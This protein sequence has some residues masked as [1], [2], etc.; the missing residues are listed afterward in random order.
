MFNPHAAQTLAVFSH[1]NHELSVLMTLAR[2]EPLIVFLT[3]GGGPARVE[4]SRAGLKTVGLEKKARFMQNTEESFYRAI[5]AKDSSFFK[6]VAA[7]LSNYLTLHEPVQIITDAV[8]FYNPVH[9]ISLPLVRKAVGSSEVPIY[10]VPL[11]Y[12]QRG[13]PDCYVLQD[14]PPVWETEHV[15]VCL[16]DEESE[17][18]SVAYM[19]DY[20]IIRNTMGLLVQ[21]NPQVLRREILVRARKP[22]SP[23][24]EHYGRRYDRRGKEGVLAGTY[25]QAILS[26][27][28]Y[29]ETVAGLMRESV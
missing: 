12:E 6:G 24:F 8:E 20:G 28:H 2:V 26:D 1:P 7:H 13:M 21:A 23:A 14:A 3:D 17:A 15:E 27:V 19:N 22:D 25:E 18:K 11:I 5:L 9:D 16:T 29:K 10:E 4:E